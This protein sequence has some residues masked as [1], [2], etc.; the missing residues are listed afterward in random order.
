MRH[1]RLSETEI[2]C[3]AGEY[4]SVRMI[5]MRSSKSRVRAKSDGS[6]NL[7]E[8]GFCR[9]LA[10]IADTHFRLLHGA[11]AAGMNLSRPS[12]T[13]DSEA[14]S[15]SLAAFPTSAKP[16]RLA[17]RLWSPARLDLGWSSDCQIIHL[18]YDLISASDGN[19]GAESARC[20]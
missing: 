6:N 19:P 16:I 15:R 3:I 14:G 10:R 18:I 20:L 5:L 2:Y 12:L 9:K 13:T 8:G 4:R 17:I 1:H 11:E 7:H